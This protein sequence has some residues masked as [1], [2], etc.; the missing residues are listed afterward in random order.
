MHIYISIQTSL[1]QYDDD[2]DNDDDDDYNKN[3]ISY[4]NANLKASYAWPYFL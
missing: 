4:F 3:R 2:D 1:L